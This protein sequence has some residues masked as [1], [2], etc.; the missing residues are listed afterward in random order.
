MKYSKKLKTLSVTLLIAASLMTSW[1]SHIARASECTAI[2]TACDKALADQDRVINFKTRAIEA[3]QEIIGAQDTRIRILEED[4]N[5]I[6]KSPWLYFG[7]GVV[8]GALL[9]RK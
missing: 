9:L 1:P 7:L 3:Q 4:K 5:S 2:V 6:F 8:T